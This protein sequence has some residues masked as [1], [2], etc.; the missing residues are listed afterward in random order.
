VVPAEDLAALQ[1][2]EEKIRVDEQRLKEISET[3]TIPQKPTDA[4][5]HSIEPLFEDPVPAT[6]PAPVAEP[7]LEP[8]VTPAIPVIV[9]SVSNPE[10]LAPSVIPVPHEI[11]IQ[12]TDAVSHSIE[13]LFEDFVPDTEPA[14]VAEPIPEP[15]VTPAIPVIVP[16][17]SNPETPSPSVIP[18][19]HEVP[20][21]PTDAVSHSIEPLFEDPVPATEPIPRIEREMPVSSFATSPGPKISAVTQA[22]VSQPLPPVPGFRQTSAKQRTSIIVAVIIVILVVAAGVFVLLKLL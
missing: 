21:Q 5:N 14:P 19:P 12:P 7:M 9:P 22:P 15:P 17:V 11:R 2:L 10:T 1:N 20:I 4:V 18:V 3:R 16:S 13:P 8:P 6:E